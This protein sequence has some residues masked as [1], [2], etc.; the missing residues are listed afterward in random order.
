V[1]LGNGTVNFSP[2]AGT[3]NSGGGGGGGARNDNGHV[4]GANGGAGVVM[5]H[6]RGASDAATGG[7]MGTIDAATRNYYRRFDVTGALGGLTIG[8]NQAALFVGSIAGAGNLILNGPGNVIVTG[9]NSYG[10]TTISAGALQVGAGGLVGTLGSGAITNHARLIFNRSNAIAIGAGIRGSGSLTQIGSGTLT[11]SGASSYT[12]ATTVSNGALEVTGSLAS[13]VTV[14]S[15]AT[16][17]GTGTI[18]NSVVIKPG[19]F[20]TT[21]LPGAPLTVNGKLTVAGTLNITDTGGFGLGTYTLFSYTGTLTNNDLAIGATPNP[22]FQYQLD[23]SVAGQVRLVVQA[24]W[25]SWQMQ[26]FGCTNCPQAALTADPDGDGLANLIERALGLDP[27][28]AG[29]NPLLFDR[30]A[31]DTNTYLRLSVT[32]DPAVTD[33]LIEGLSVGTLSDSNAWSSATTFIESNTP[34]FFRV[35]DAL[36]IETNSQR[37]LKL[38]FSMP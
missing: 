10:A 16:I 14:V 9:G 8:S 11:L 34:S 27:T 18:N 19:A 12:G 36:P 26:Y 17:G 37:F 4:N 1:V 7:S 2:V 32:R 6:Y 15:G 38:R 23:T 13:S 24:T 22:L 29:V 30:E 28:V 35:R 25:E 33:V 21:R 5:V 31:I 20:I 3:A